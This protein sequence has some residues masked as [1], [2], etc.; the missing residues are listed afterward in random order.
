MRDAMSD[1]DETLP[2]MLFLLAAT[3]APPA[4]EEYLRDIP[5]FPEKRPDVDLD[6]VTSE[7]LTVYQ[8]NLDIGDCYPWRVIETDYPE[9]AAVVRVIATERKKWAERLSVYVKAQ[10]AIRAMEWRVEWADQLYEQVRLRELAIAKREHCQDCGRE[11][12][13]GPLGEVLLC[14]RGCRM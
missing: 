2:R 7:A 12:P 11:L 6:K 1:G 10:R 14:D 3:Q 5:F 8:R 4:S 13:R 9:L